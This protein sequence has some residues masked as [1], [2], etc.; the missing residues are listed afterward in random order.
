M[1]YLIPLLLVLTVFLSCETAP[2][3][4]NTPQATSEAPARGT[5][6]EKSAAI[7]DAVTEAMGG[8]AAYD[9]LR[10]L[11][12]NF[13]GVRDLIWDKQTGRVRIDSP[14]D[15][16]VYLV[17]IRTNEGQVMR[18]GEK[19]TRPDSLQKYS[20]QGKSIWINDAYWLV[21][22][23]KLRDPGVNL[24]YLRSDTT[25][26]GAAAEVLELTFTETGDTPDNKY[27]VFVDTSDNLIK[28]W[29]FYKDKNQPEPSAVWPW[30]NYQSYSGVLLSANRSDQKGPSDVRV[31]QELPAAVFEDFAAPNL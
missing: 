2:T 28:Q 12:W 1:Q 18:G 8:Q 11:K 15:S 7:A 30:D 14:R 31:Y 5:A 6:D 29:A 13:F 16:T 25:L 24:K 10:Y 23:F 20:G 22:P 9:S 19:I 21:M 17:N 26:T 4:G 3:P 27:E